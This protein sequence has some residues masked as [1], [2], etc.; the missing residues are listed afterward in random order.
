MGFLVVLG[1][2]QQHVLISVCT[3]LI[4]CCTL[5]WT[6]WELIPRDSKHQ[7]HY[8]WY[9]G[10]GILENAGKVNTSFKGCDFSLPQHMG[11][12][13]TLIV[14]QYN[15]KYVKYYG[16]YNLYAIYLVEFID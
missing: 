15:D 8:F 7:P 5:T 13:Q 3:V 1:N 2:D 12:C 11:I 6:D 4:T 16:M 10:H 14:L 9:Q